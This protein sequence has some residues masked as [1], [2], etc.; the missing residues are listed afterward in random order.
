MKSWV[1]IGLLSLMPVS[2]YAQGPKP[3][4]ELKAEIA[5][6]LEA[7][8]VKSYTLEIVPTEKAEGVEGKVV[9]GCEGG[10]KK[11][12]YRRGEGSPEKPAAE[13]A[14]P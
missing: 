11:I 8:G 9:G 13:P 10:T 3:C 12:V 5:K 6:K 7:N 1:M 14:K 2:V 4:E